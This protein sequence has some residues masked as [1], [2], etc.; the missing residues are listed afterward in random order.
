MAR[1]VVQEC[2]RSNLLYAIFEH[3]DRAVQVRVMCRMIAD[4]HAELVS[5]RGGLL[6]ARFYPQAAEVAP[7][8]D[9]HA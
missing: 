8:G 2:R 6:M 9:D 4:L 7:W 1:S 5:L 3:T